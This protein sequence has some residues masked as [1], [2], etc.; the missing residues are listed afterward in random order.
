M[1]FKMD[2]KKTTIKELVSAVTSNA[3]NFYYL[4]KRNNP[5]ID[6]VN[7]VEH[8]S[9]FCLYELNFLGTLQKKS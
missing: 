3:S 1:R 2:F 5:T 4:H 8:E 9:C 6:T 7:Y